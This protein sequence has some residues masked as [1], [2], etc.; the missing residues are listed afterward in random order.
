MTALTLAQPEHLDQ[1]TRLVADFHTEMNIDQSD[2]ARRAALL[3]LLEG[4][5]HG[6]I[7]LAGPTRAPIGYGIVTFGWSVE[8]GGM[9][10]FVDEIYIRP[11][12]RGRGIGTEVLAALAKGLKSTG[13]KA[14]HLE[15]DRDDTHA[16]SV[17]EKQHFTARPRYMLMTRKF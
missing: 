13:M 10:G 17:Y 4:S 5:P 15:V 14:L 11:G 6:A 7:Y 16:Q 1:V 3:P 8:M 12:V 2:D 9:D